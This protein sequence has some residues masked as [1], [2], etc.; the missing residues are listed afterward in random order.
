MLQQCT[1]SI[2]QLTVPKVKE[3]TYMDFA[4]KSGNPVFLKY[5]GLALL[6]VGLTIDWSVDITHPS[7]TQVDLGLSQL[8]FKLSVHHGHVLRQTT[9]CTR[10]QTILDFLELG[11]EP[12]KTQAEQNP[13][14]TE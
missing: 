4:S 14:I 11:R 3:K 5:H 10:L 9:I 7:C 8:S 12:T 6:M 2:S 1:L 13:H